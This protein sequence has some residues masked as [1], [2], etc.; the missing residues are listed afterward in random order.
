MTDTETKSP[1]FYGW[2]IAAAGFIGMMCLGEVMW[3]F[4]VFFT[5]LEEEFGWSRSLT[6]S[7]YTFLVL[8]YAVS[9]IV[10]GRITDRRTARPVFFASAV[11]AGPAIMLCSTIQ[12]VV[13]LQILLF[14]TGLGAGALLSAPTS[15]VQRWFH[16]R[17]RSGI[18]L[19]IVMAG[20]GAG[21]LVFAPA[22]NYLIGHIG[23]R[24]TFIL[25]G[26][27]FLIAV[28]VSGLM[29]RPVPP[30]S[31][32]V[33]GVDL[34]PEEARSPTR[35]LIRSPKF[36]LATGI[37]GVSIFGFQAVNVH[38]MPMVTDAGIDGS[39]AAAALGLAGGF[40]VIGR[41][42]C[43]ILSERL[44][45]ARTFAL[46]Q[47]AVGS[48]M[49]LLALVDQAWALYCVVGL[50]GIGQGARA[51]SVTGTLGQIFGLHVIGE[52][53]GILSAVGQLSGSAG[54]YVAGFLHDTLGSYQ[55]ILVILGIV[56]LATAALIARFLVGPKLR[57]VAHTS[58]AVSS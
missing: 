47:I 56:Y 29:I 49:L 27:F 32:G 12:S 13:H 24:P 10:A 45:W 11:I 38:L 16:N 9:A 21:G 26:L 48:A 54:P 3:S 18:A 28:G 51:V 7:G 36:V 40:S 35:S 33:A 17:P 39:V 19:A 1:V 15:T 37:M 42:T 58:G 8:G 50:Y 23:W 14:V 25:A 31:R 2:F 57:I 34:P 43:G 53:T 52:L 44:S 30:A 22:I 5:A 46:S 4:G 6:S 41:L 55:L 20:V